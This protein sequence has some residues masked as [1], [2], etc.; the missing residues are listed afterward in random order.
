MTENALSRALPADFNR[1]V[2]LLYIIVILALFG[3]G[4]GYMFYKGKY[5]YLGL[6]LASPLLIMILTQ[7]KLAV[8]QF[9]FALFISRLIFE[10]QPW[11]WADLSGIILTAAAWLDLFSE[12]KFHKG[13][14]RLSF[15]FLLL[16]LVIF[17]AGLFSYQ[18]EAAFNPLG[19]ITLLF[20]YFLAIYRLSGK[21]NMSWSLNLFFGLSVIHSI[22][23]LIP[24]LASGGNFRSYGL[25]PVEMAMLA[26][27]VATAKYLWAKE[28]TGWMYLMGMVVIFFALLSGQFRTLVIIGAAMS[29]LVVF[30]SRRR[31]KLELAMDAPETGGTGTEELSRVKKRPLY[32][33]AG[34]LLSVAFV[35]MLSPQLLAP[36]LERFERLVTASPSGSLLLRI[37]LWKL[38]WSQFIDN[39]FVGIGPGLFNQIQNVVPVIRMDFFHFYVRGLSAHNLLLHYLAEAGIIGAVAVLAMM[40]NQMCLSYKAWLVSAS[41]PVLEVSAILLGIS[42]TILFTTLTESSWL[43]GQ[44]SIVFAFFLA[45]V[46][47][48]HNNLV[49]AKRSGNS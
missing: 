5:L 25:A 42:T 24:F 30:F 45:L 19:R 8:G 31:A 7:P 33:L 35:I 49:I 39:P 2:F 32:L 10:G 47:R 28:G 27:V 43:W 46:A 3:L 9:I 34:L 6:I 37:T 4:L 41:R 36:L 48:N 14:P 15:N 29:I 16:L 18:P 23:V 22:I 26:L 11:L 21:V 17:T 38:A 1:P 44:S 13:L 40:I 20:L 12:S